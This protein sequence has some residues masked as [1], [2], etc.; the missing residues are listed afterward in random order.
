MYLGMGGP[1]STCLSVTTVLLS[2]PASPRSSQNGSGRATLYS[3]ALVHQL[4][5]E[6]FAADVP[7]NIAVV[8]TDEGVRLTT[9]VVDCP[10]EGL[11]I[12]MELDVTVERL[13]DEVAIPKF[14]PPP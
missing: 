14:R 9:Q 4:Y 10:N 1:R 12:G 8:E 11:A 7:Y 6:A 13:S 3:F 2:T 5:D